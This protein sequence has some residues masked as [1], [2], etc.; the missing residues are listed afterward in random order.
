M[1][2]MITRIIAIVTMIIAITMVVIPLIESTEADDVNTID[3]ILIDGQSN[4][5]Y[6]SNNV[7][8]C[9]PAI[10]NQELGAPDHKAL[11]YGT[12]NSSSRTVSDSSTIRNMYRSGEWKI[13]GE[14]AGL[15][16]YLMQKNHRDVLV[17]NIARGAT[18]IQEL[19]TGETWTNGR[20][21]IEAALAEIDQMYEAKNFVGWV[22]IHGEADRN[23]SKAYYKQYFNILDDN[24]AQLGF[25]QCYFAL[26][27]YSWGLNAYDAMLEL[28]ASDPN[29]H[30]ATDITSTFTVA[31]GLLNTDDLHYTQK[32]RLVLARAIIAD[33][34]ANPNA[35]SNNNQLWQIIPV[36]LFISVIVLAIQYRRSYN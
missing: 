24:L 18:G 31:N 28:A 33:I 9:D 4:G 26:P 19:A 11:Y 29:I 13:G 25:E 8:R 12:Q 23:Q 20:A 34:P 32:G 22:M 10:V 36:L 3:I 2:E 21:V 6:Y 5:A 27:R 15:A 16:Y 14:E 35:D 30:I 1:M 17:L 7:S